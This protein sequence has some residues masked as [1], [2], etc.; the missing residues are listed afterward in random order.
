MKKTQK[1]TLLALLKRRWVTPLESAL[2]G[3]GFALSQ[4][5]GEFR[6][7]GICIVDK[8]V[9]TEGGARVKAYRISAPT[10]WTA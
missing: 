4:R 9:K 5:V 3:G 10:K 7:A 6:A 8:W 2:A 1:A